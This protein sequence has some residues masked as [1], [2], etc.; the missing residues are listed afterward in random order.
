VTLLS[1]ALRPLPDKF[2][3]LKDSELRARMRYVD[4]IVNPEARKNAL[5]RSKAIAAIRAEFARRDF[6]E[7]EGSTLQTIPGGGEALPFITH[8]NALDLDMYMRI[9]LELHLKRLVVGGME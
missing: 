6:V 5:V 9:A 8:H 2:H 1:K 3:G 4:L 7:V